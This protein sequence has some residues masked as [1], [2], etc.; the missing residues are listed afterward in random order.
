[1]FGILEKAIKLR[2]SLKGLKRRPV[3]EFS[4]VRKLYKEHK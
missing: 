1:M 2:R 4:D 3:L